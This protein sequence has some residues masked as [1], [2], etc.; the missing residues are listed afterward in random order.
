MTAVLPPTAVMTNE[1]FR[2]RFRR[3]LG[4]V[5]SM[6]IVEMQNVLNSPKV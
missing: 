3:V 1:S 6:S 5:Y 4:S 2:L